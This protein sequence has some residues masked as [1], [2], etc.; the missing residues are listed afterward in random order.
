ML[1]VVLYVFF[2]SG[3]LLCPSDCFL[4]REEEKPVEL[5]GWYLGEVEG[6]KHSQNILDEKFFPQPKSKI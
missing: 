5:D 1:F 4:K 6:G 2:N 3:Y